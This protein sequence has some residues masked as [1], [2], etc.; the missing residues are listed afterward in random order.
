MIRKLAILLSIFG[1]VAIIMG[2]VFIIAFGGTGL[3]L[4]RLG[5]LSE[6]RAG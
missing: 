2:G 1:L 4:L 6:P 5:R 3:A